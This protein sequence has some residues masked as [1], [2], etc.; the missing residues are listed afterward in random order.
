MDVRQKGPIR[1]LKS[2][3]PF[4]SRHPQVT[5]PFEP[6]DPYPCVGKPATYPYPRYPTH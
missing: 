6:P 3:M 1:C 5:H 4:L 2:G